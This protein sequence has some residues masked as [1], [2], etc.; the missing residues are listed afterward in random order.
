MCLQVAVRL[1]RWSAVLEKQQP[2]VCVCVCVSASSALH[3]SS[4]VM[5]EFL[6]LSNRKGRLIFFYEWNIKLKWNG[7]RRVLAL[8][9]ECVCVHVHTSDLCR[10]CVG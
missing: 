10:H 1:R 2:G 4:V 3:V 5:L 6:L 7:T 8:F 9:L